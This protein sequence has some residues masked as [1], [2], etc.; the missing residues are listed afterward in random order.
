MVGGAAHVV[1]VIKL[2]LNESV[3]AARR[4]P[5]IDP[6]PR[7][8]ALVVEGYIDGGRSVHGVVVSSAG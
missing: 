8:A 7:E 5:A 4:K 2:A 3:C 1:E 6:L